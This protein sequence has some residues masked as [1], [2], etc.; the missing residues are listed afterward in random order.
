ML[1][2]DCAQRF[3]I[4]GVSGIGDPCFGEAGFQCF[5]ENIGAQRTTVACNAVGAAA[6][7]GRFGHELP[8][9]LGVDLRPQAFGIDPKGH[10]TFYL[11]TYGHGTH[12][13]VGWDRRGEQVIFASHMLGDVNVCVATIPKA[14]QDAWA[15]QC[16]MEPR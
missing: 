9:G 10:F 4:D 6:C 7:P 12:P 3:D 1:Q 11:D 8:F 5:D 15:S 16:S 14:W 2:A 13:E